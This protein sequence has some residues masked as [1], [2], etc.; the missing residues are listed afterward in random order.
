MRVPLVSK[1]SRISRY[2]KFNVIARMAFAF[3]EVHKAQVKLKEV[4]RETTPWISTLKSR[5]GYAQV[6]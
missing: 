1:A 4:P 5:I 6:T 2:C 3:G